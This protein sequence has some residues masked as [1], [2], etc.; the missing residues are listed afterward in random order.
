M[1]NTSAAK[2]CQKQPLVEISC[3]ESILPQPPQEWVGAEK[4]NVFKVIAFENDQKT[5]A[6]PFQAPVSFYYY[7]FIFN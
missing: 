7:S 5:Q 4:E 2:S 6:T 3:H 1:E